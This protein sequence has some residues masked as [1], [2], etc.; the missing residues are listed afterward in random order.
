MNIKST[1]L[2]LT[3][4]LLAVTVQ[5]QDGWNWP[6]GADQ[7]AKAREFNAAYTDYMNSEQFVEATGPLYWLFVN[8]PDL[9]ESIYINGVTIY[10]G[11]ADQVADE[12]KKKVYQDSVITIYEKRG[13]LY[14]NE[15]KWIENKAYYSYGFYK[16]DKTKLGDVVANFEKAIEL[17][18]EL[19][20]P[21]LYS[22]YFD[23]VY[24]H[25]AYNKVYEPEEVLE[26]YNSIQEDLNKLETAGTDVTRPRN[27]TEKILVAMKLIDCDFIDNTLG[28]KLAAD[29]ENEELADQIFKYSVQYKCFSSDTFLAALE[30]KDSKNPTF[31]TSQVRA[32]RYLQDKDYEKAEPALNQALGLAEND[33]Q[34]A[35]IQFELAQ[36]Y[37]SQGKK[38][39]ARTAAR[40]VASLD[41]EKSSEAWKLIGDLYI[42]SSNDCRGG[43][44][45][46]KDYSIFI[47]AYNAYQ[48]AGN[49]AGMA[50][51]RAR[52]PS[53]EELFTEGLQVGET[54]NTGCWIGETVT[55]ATRD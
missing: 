55:L 14:N 37:A 5:A 22:A 17:N 52:F 48:R 29:P 16:G 26:V 13:E 31:A 10:K 15:S 39:A 12:A 43:V 38:S 30:L 2:G 9:N 25:N 51:A 24:R 45:R 28:P 35:E 53:K 41:E 33:Q 49:S 27:T 21:D 7:E 36:V 47:A 19:S 20:L 23:A 54:L 46:A 8:A 3:A 32:M 6:A 42:S 1:L 11:A 50:N 44:S 18:G 34:K 40:E 4:L